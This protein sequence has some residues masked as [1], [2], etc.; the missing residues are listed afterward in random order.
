MIDVCEMAA[1]R[2]SSASGQT[3]KPQDFAAASV[4]LSLAR[5]KKVNFSEDR[6]EGFQIEIRGPQH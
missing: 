1:I 3:A 2:R 4:S 5:L 6:A